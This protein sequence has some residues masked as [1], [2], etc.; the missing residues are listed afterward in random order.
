MGRCYL[1][2]PPVRASQTPPAAASEYTFGSPPL[3]ER[4]SVAVSLGMPH[5]STQSQD[6]APVPLPWWSCAPGLLQP[7]C[8]NHGLTAL[9]S[10]APTCSDHPKG[11]SIVFW[12]SGKPS[13]SVL[14]L[15]VS[16]LC[17]PLPRAPENRI[18]GL[19][20]LESGRTCKKGSGDAVVIGRQGGS[21]NQARCARLWATVPT[22]MHVHYVSVSK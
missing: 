19:L 22:P 11:M 10:R 2:R 20:L 18:Q 21:S 9:K 1:Q 8:V 5:I 3:L 7:I 16:L 15:S 4:N 14:Y 13:R 17:P 6:P 12:L